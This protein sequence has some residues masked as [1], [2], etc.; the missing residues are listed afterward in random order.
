VRGWPGIE[1]TWARPRRGRGW[2]VRDGLTGGVR[3]AEREDERVRKETAPT[4]RPHR[5]AR[6]REGARG[7]APTG[8]VRLS[9][10]DG[11]R[12]RG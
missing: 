8:G 12:P 3:G 1:R 7:L 4:G 5:A 10:A 9:G 2:E 11:A 6:G